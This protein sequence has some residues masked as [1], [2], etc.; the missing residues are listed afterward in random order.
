M[1]HASFRALFHVIMLCSNSPIPRTLISACRVQCQCVQVHWATLPWPPT[2]VINVTN[3]NGSQHQC[4]FQSP[5]QYDQY[6]VPCVLYSMSHSQ[7]SRYYC[8]RKC[9]ATHHPECYLHAQIMSIYHA[10]SRVCP[11]VSP[12]YLVCAQVHYHGLP[13]ASH[14]INQ[15]MVL[16]HPFNPP[17]IAYPSWWEMLSCQAT[18][19]SYQAHVLSCQITPMCCVTTMCCVLPSLILIVQCFMS[20][21]RLSCLS[22][23]CSSYLIGSCIDRVG[24]SMVICYSSHD[25][26]ISQDSLPMSSYYIHHHVGMLPWKWKLRMHLDMHGEWS[27]YVLY[28]WMLRLYGWMRLRLNSFHV[29]V[30]TVMPHACYGLQKVL[31]GLYKIVVCWMTSL[32]DLLRIFALIPNPIGFD[33]F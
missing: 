30:L 10:S 28:V 32:M 15:C 22:P 17:I 9:A 26:Y 18:L 4:V 23:L 25:S 31:I 1:C 12:G 14:V 8:M 2:C 13:S 6:I 20:T 33:S 11:C 27:M 5:P 21:P 16:L 7:R 29:N 24:N 3:L 19:M